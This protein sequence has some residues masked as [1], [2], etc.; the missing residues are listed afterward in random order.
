MASAR[1]LTDHDQIRGWA[2]ERGARPACVRG[3]GTDGDA[4]ILRFDFPGFTGAETLEEISW[5]LWFEA[6][7][8]NQL[9]LVVQDE[10][11]SGSRSHF[12]QLIDRERVE[13]SNGA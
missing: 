9:A 1:A 10:T 8:R 13:S 12:N 11:A 2:E 3:T 5:E 4:G 6:F 7:E